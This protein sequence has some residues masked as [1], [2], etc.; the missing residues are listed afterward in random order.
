MMPQILCI[1]GSPV[2]VGD[3]SRLSLLPP[4]LWLPLLL[5]W[6]SLLLL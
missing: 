3:I 6:L 5:L 4:M 2:D 1:D